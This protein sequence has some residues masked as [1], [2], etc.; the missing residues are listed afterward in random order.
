MRWTAATLAAL[1]VLSG[2]AEDGPTPA[3]KA[4]Q[5][6]R[7]IAMVEAAQQ[8]KPPPQAI[9]LEPMNSAEVTRY[10]VSTAC[11]FLPGKGGAASPILLAG[12]DR[13]W[14]KI[15]AR[16]HGLAADRGSTKFAGGAWPNYDGKERSVTIDAER[17]DGVTIGDDR[18]RWAANVTVRDAYDQVIFRGAGTLECGA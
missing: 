12:E 17:G 3:E 18:L 9:D 6:A 10:G 14:L 16:I 2:C 8:T 11:A 13:A 4:A 7:D 15:G 1:A 5:D